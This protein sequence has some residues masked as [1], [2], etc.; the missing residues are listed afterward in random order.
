M[1][2]LKTIIELSL[3]RDEFADELAAF[4]KQLVRD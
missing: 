4:M 3:Q 2:W 1:G